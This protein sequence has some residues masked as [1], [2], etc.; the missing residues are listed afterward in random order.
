[1][2]HLTLVHFG[3]PRAD[4]TNLALTRVYT[5]CQEHASY[6]LLPLVQ[7][8]PADV[9]PQ[10]GREWFIPPARRNLTSTA[11][12]QQPCCRPRGRLRIGEPGLAVGCGAGQRAGSRARAARHAGVQLPLC[13]RHGGL[14]ACA[15]RPHGPQ[16]GAAGRTCHTGCSAEASRA[17]PAQGGAVFMRMPIRHCLHLRF[18][19][20][21]T[22]KSCFSRILHERTGC[23]AC[24][25]A[26]PQCKQHPSCSSCFKQSVPQFPLISS[27]GMCVQVLTASRLPG[28][29]HTS[30]RAAL[31]APLGPARDAIGLV[32]YPRWDVQARRAGRP[33]FGARFGGWLPGVAEFD[34]GLFG[35][36]APEAQLM[37]PQQRLLLEV[38]GSATPCAARMHPALAAVG[39][40]PSGLHAF[41][42]HTPCSTPAN[43]VVMPF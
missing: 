3:E 7:Q 1:M 20:Q 39:T 32:P 9:Q 11:Y 23:A 6:Q 15:A 25:N 36:S 13:A 2:D 10:P 21:C 35:V 4:C 30:S 14:P 28:N 5:V 16:G 22:S 8:H 26:S 24:R 40:W 33:A 42:G 19:M 43:K 18:V 27:A 17:S 34:A 29:A 31:A 37:D 41:T 12:A 38:P